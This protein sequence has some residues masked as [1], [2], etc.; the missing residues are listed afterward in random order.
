M[1][2]LPFLPKRTVALFFMLLIT[3][4][5]IYVTDANGMSKPEPDC[6]TYGP[7]PQEGIVDVHLVNSSG[8]LSHVTRQERNIAA[9]AAM[10]RWNQQSESA[11]SFVY[12]GLVSESHYNNNK[13][14]Y[15]V[16]TTHNTCPSGR[17]YFSLQCAEK[18]WQIV[19]CDS[20]L[21]S[22]G[23]PR[24]N[25]YDV[26]KVLEDHSDVLSVL[27]HEFGHA[28]GLHHPALNDPNSF[29]EYCDGNAAVLG[30]SYCND[31]SMH[32]MSRRDLYRY[33]NYCASQRNSY[34]KL[35]LKSILS[36]GTIMQPSSY[37]MGNGLSNAAI[38]QDNSSNENYLDIRTPSNN[39]YR[40]HRHFPGTPS[41]YDSWQEDESLRTGQTF[42]IGMPASSHETRSGIKNDDENDEWLQ[43][44]Y[45]AWTEQYPY[46]TSMGF[47][48]WITAT[49]CTAASCL[50]RVA[51]RSL[52]PIELVHNAKDDT[53]YGMWVLHDRENENNAYRVNIAEYVGSGSTPRF[54][55]NLL[56]S[57]NVQFQ[58]TTKPTLHCGARSSGSANT[59]VLFYIPLTDRLNRLHSI[60][61]SRTGNGFEASP[62]ANPTMTTIDGAT[63]SIGSTLTSWKFPSNI[64][65]STS[66]YD[67]YV[68]FAS[69]G[70]GFPLTILKFDANGQNGQKV[71]EWSTAISSPTVSPAT[72][73]ST[74]T[75]LIWLGP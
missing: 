32:E 22:N 20:T 58:A 59:C 64:F 11:V 29:N 12:Q 16:V 75:Y 66:D 52:Y 44:Y 63:Y 60:S 47:V 55:E 24:S 73:N 10:M 18:K 56:K 35:K 65:N 31:D 61:L 33:D 25:D 43:R 9:I 14:N 23:I 74:L 38:W 69:S 40:E 2:A 41:F 46:F 48:D 1:D 28:Q 71:G 54:A 42:T 26:G 36:F 72:D 68:A 5:W 8:S 37:G 3:C 50:N 17:A 34:R 15:N 70:P 62:N 51:I 57:S 21:D 30:A 45:A 19:L 67:V 53:T 7:L 4:C 49:R 27:V 6:K 13:C 39:F